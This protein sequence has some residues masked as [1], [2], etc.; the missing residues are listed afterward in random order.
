MQQEMAFTLVFMI[1]SIDTMFGIRKVLKLAQKALNDAQVD[2]ALIGGLALGGQGVHR[3]TM[4]VDLLVD[5]EKS[6]IAQ[7]ALEQVGFRLS[8]QTP[9]V[10]ILGD[11][12]L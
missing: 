12:V 11:R 8:T 10:I 9:E 2:Y 4:D 1:G 5:G 6:D 7:Q 3:A